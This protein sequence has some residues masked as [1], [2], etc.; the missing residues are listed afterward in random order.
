MVIDIHADFYLE[1][2]NISI[3]KDNGK[4]KKQIQK[5]RYKENL[6][7]KADFHK[8]TEQKIKIRL[9]NRYKKLKLFG[10]ESN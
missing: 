10:V 4:N 1:P 2:N 6:D 3:K 8:V 5:N 9:C 7:V